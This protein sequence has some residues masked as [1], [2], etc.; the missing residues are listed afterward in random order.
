MVSE[1]TP[2]HEQ[3]GQSVVMEAVVPVNMGGYLQRVCDTVSR[4][5]NIMLDTSRAVG[6]SLPRTEMRGAE[7][8]SAKAEGMKREWATMAAPQCGFSRLL[9]RPSRFL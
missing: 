1:L 7:M 4:D 8:P 6:S 3:E 2:G 5:N 9:Q